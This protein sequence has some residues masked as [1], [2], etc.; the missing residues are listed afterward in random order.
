M[1]QF[2]GITHNPIILDDANTAPQSQ[3]TNWSQSPGRVIDLV[4]TFGAWGHLTPGLI[5]YY[6]G[7]IS[8]ICFIVIIRFTRYSHE[9]ATASR[10]E[11][12]NWCI[13]T[14]VLWQLY[15]I[16]KD[17]SQ[18]RADSCNAL[19]VASYPA[20][21]DILCR[22]GKLIGPV[23]GLV[24][25]DWWILWDSLLLKI[26]LVVKITFISS[27]SSLLWCSKELS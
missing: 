8:V 15:H 5:F 7:P 27:S 12:I 24:V 9:H 16:R 14:R 6:N 17:M 23:R 18:I 11:M 10:I 4:Q 13:S 19:I 25:M 26:N 1:Y 2:H 21:C 20:Q 22:V 3:K